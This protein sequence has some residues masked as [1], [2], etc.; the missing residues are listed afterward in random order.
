MSDDIL[1]T[2]EAP[3]NTRKLNFGPGDTVRV[4]VK[5]VEEKKTRI[6]VF[7]GTVLSIR[8]KGISRTFTVRKISSG[9]GVER[10][11]PLQSPMI[12]KVEVAMQGRVRR[13]KIYYIRNKKGKAARIP[14]KKRKIETK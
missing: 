14:Q 5:I 12:D 13:S 9:I 7:Q 4:H 10:V 1:K 8:G 3:Y 11:F 6:Q 2:V